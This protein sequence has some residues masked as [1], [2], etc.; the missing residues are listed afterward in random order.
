[1]KKNMISKSG[2]EIERVKLGEYCYKNYS[3]K[4]EKDNSKPSWKSDNMGFT[5]WVIADNEGNI[6]A[7]TTTLKNALVWIDFQTSTINKVFP[8]SEVIGLKDII[9]KSEYGTKRIIDLSIALSYESLCHM[10]KNPYNYN[11]GMQKYDYDVI[12]KAGVKIKKW[13]GEIVTADFTSEE[14]TAV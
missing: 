2:R 8:E 9:I 12:V 5:K 14:L 7:D 10:M 13:D 3:I 4:A 6:K 11:F 1:M